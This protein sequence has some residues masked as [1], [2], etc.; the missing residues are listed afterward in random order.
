[1][2]VYY[3]EDSQYSKVES[4][5]QQAIQIGNAVSTEFVLIEE[6]IKAKG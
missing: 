5:L 1:M 3:R 4:L 6:V 2:T